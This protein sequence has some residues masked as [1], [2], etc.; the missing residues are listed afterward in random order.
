M[1]NEMKNVIVYG[2][3]KW[4]HQF[5]KE[6]SLDLNIMFC[7]DR[8]K[9]QGECAGV[10]I[11]TWE[12]VEG[13]RRANRIVIAAHELYIEEIYRRIIYQCDFYSLEIYDCRG[14]N[15]REIYK[16]I[17]NETEWNR[18]FSNY[19]YQIL[20]EMIDRY[21]AVSFDLFDTLIMRK[22]LE[23]ID[24]FDI[25]KRRIIDIVS[26]SGFKILRHEAEISVDACINSFDSIYEELIIEKHISKDDADIVKRTEMIVEKEIIVPR[27]TMIEA[28]LY[29]VSAGKQVSIISDMYLPKAFLI[30][31]ME[32][33]GI[34]NYSD[35]ILSC[36]N[37]TTKERELFQDYK[38]SVG[39]K[40]CL[41]IGDHKNADEISAIKAGIDAV[42]IPSAIEMMRNSSMRRVLYYMHSNTER[43]LIGELLAKVFS[44][45]FAL[46]GAEGIIKISSIDVLG[47]FFIAPL[48][49]SY[50]KLLKEQ[51]SAG[52]YENVLLGARDGFMFDRIIR[53]T[54]M[55]SKEEK[56]KYKYILISRGLAYKL[57]MGNT[58]VDKDYDNYLLVDKRRAIPPDELFQTGV[59]SIPYQETKISYL[60]YLESLGIDR[61]KSCLF[62]DLISGGT[63]QYC[64]K[65]LFPSG[66]DG[67]YMGRTFYYMDR[68]I[69]VNSL[70][71]REEIPHNEIF[72]DRIETFLC[73]PVPTV[74]DINS[75]G[76]FIYE[77]EYRG[78]EELTLLNEIQDSVISG[79]VDLYK[80]EKLYGDK[81]N[82]MMSWT[83][84][85]LLDQ[86]D[87]SGEIEALNNWVYLENNGE[88]SKLFEAKHNCV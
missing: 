50:L 54:D 35:F 48:V 57:G 77:I 43:R 2:T 22:V 56:V 81:L 87:F 82:K 33:F 10:E 24:A 76:E 80:W 73:A 79:V 20:C 88:Q 69:H 65:P 38:R 78:E 12:Y 31:I 34:K 46:C 36:D 68:D 67:F 83:L 40:R 85:D 8:S 30:E 6:H 37:K 14:L 72:V 26:I 4:A 71:E 23:P 64:M 32:S 13:L 66:L 25:V 53:E 39:D 59:H 74:K 1:I 63:V 29:A 49:F 52:K 45:P 42:H 62:C 19:N 51:V 3:G 17:G 41:H 58:E 61:F 9:M 75:N 7:L 5:I 47:R 86:L 44:D 21:D 18:F 70:Y 11:K 15:L 27:L 84:F 16:Y 55:F 28:F 60:K